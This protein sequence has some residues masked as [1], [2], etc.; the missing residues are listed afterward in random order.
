[1]REKD[2]PFDRTKHMVYTNNAKKCVQKLLHR[3]YDEQT[4]ARLWEKV[5]LKYCEYLK[6]EPAMAGLKITTSI[7]DPILIFA[8]Y[9]VVPDKPALEEVQQDIYRSFFGSFGVM[10]KVFNLN[11]KPDNRLAASIFQKANDIRVEEIKK[12]PESFRMGCCAY[13]K[14]DGVIRYSFTQ[15]PNAEFAKR[16]HM[17]D[18]L[19]VMCNCDHLAMQK[20]HATLIREGTCCTASCCDYC[21]VGNQNP[22]AKAYELVKRENG[23]LV[24]VRKQTK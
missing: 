10:G 21:I 19:P 3:Y 13:E 22:L 4:A 20:L 16:H 18:V 7:Y 11:R 6:D 15:C 2:L 8:W 9:A 23:L 14:E 12:F 1:M 24:S 5:Q 17:E